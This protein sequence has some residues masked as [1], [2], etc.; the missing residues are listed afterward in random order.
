LA[1][2]PPVNVLARRVHFDWLDHETDQW[3]HSM[4]EFGAG[5]NAV[6]LLMPHAEPYVIS[7]VRAGLSS[8]PDPSPQLTDSVE[9]WI[10]QEG[11]HFKAH[12]DFNR[13]LT[14]GSRTARALDRLGSKIFSWLDTR[15][16]A[17]GLAFAA[18]FE[19]VAFCAARWAEAGL[20]RY[21]TGAD[22]RSATLFLWHL[23][24]EIEH[25]GIAH[26]VMTEHVAATKK[27][28][29][30]VLVAF[31][32]MIGFTVVGGLALFSRHL[33]V[34]NPIRWARLIGWGFSFAFVVMPIV[35]ASVSHDFHPND[36][37]DP[38]WMAQWLLEF[39]PETQT[40]PLWSDA[41]LAAAG[42][43]TQSRPS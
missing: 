11:A 41:G 17:F 3:H 38:P 27:Y 39:D 5:A 32:V 2:P 7:K 8:L 42:R 14:A 24:E 28:K 23:A 30:A 15:S 18:A 25:K 4:P 12:R 10:K 36:L 35:S 9:T 26:D 16:D 37:V 29:L 34:F 43:L 1:A 21:F 22:E 31:A 33:S 19:L 6:S 20:R 40:L 13:S